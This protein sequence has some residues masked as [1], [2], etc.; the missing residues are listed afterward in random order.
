MI[1]LTSEMCSFLSEHA[2]DDPSRLLLSAARYPGIDVRWA[3][4]Q[5]EARRQ[6]RNKLPEWLSCATPLVFGGR[7][8]AEQCSS[9]Q[10]ARYKRALVMGETLCDLTGGMGVDCYYMSRGLRRAIY[11]ERQPALCEAA[12]YNFQQL[13]ADNIEVREGDSRQLV[14]PDVDT[15]YLDPARRAKDGSRVYDL[16]D[17]EPDVVAL[18]PMLRSHCKRLVVKVSPMADVSRL[19]AQLPQVTEV[20]VVA[21]KNECKELLLVLPGQGEE[22]PTSPQGPVIHCVDFRTSDEVH[23]DFLWGEEPQSEVQLAESGE[24]APRLSWLYEPDVTLLKAGAFRLPC[25]RYGVKKL[26]VNSH[27]YASSSKVADFPGRIFQVEEMMPF[28]NKMLKTIK[29]RLP[30]ANISVRNFPLSADALRKKLGLRDGGDNYLFGT[31]QVGVGPLLLLCRKALLLLL[32]LVLPVSAMARRDKKSE[33]VETLQT[34][35][36][37][38]G[39]EAPC[40]WYQGMEFLYLSPTL[41]ASLQPRVPDPAYDTLRFENTIWTFDG[42]LSEEDWMGQQCMQLQFKSPQGRMYRFATGRLMSQAND[43]A[44]HPAVPSLCA[45]APVKECDKRLRGKDFY[46]CINDERLFS[47]DSLSLSKF[48]PVH[49]DSV[50]VGNELSPLRICFTHPQGKQAC[51][52]TSLPNSRETSTSTSI[53]RYFS[54]SDPYLKYPNIIPEVWKLIQNNQVRI[55]MTLE[56][57]RLSLGKPQR[58]EHYNSKGGMLERWHYADRRLIEFV[59]G[60]VRRMAIER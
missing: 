26:E 51:V 20:H 24:E 25:A 14:V 5:L 21:V 22:S 46:L 13:G 6:L 10:T 57:V 60:R 34:I 28:S 36:S 30:Q 40:L 56:E 53:E 16:A 23:F 39:L 11:V 4:E 33:P 38:V 27:L 55:D 3:V 59:D 18:C 58:F 49:I 37:G 47:A 17:C 7:V 35:L 1:Q 42:I 48:V 29:S 43:T 9:E 31:T 52:Y 54:V 2:D 50:V 32:L 19:I 12:R 45:L 15:L 44:Y 41:N 8:P